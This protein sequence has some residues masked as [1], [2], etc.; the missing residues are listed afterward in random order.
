M[1]V[2]SPLSQRVEIGLVNFT[3]LIDDIQK[4]EEEIEP[5]GANDTNGKDSHISSVLP[6]S[7]SMSLLAK[8]LV[9]SRTTKKSEY[10]ENGNQDV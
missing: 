8:H 6:K 9:R 4:L 10:S 1:I 5:D 7:C 3:D 2:A